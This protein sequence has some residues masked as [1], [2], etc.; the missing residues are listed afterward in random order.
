MNGINDW[1]LGSVTAVLS[2]VGLFVASR[3][4]EEVAY[5]GGLVFFAF[6]VG[7]ILFQVKRAWDRREQ[8]R[9]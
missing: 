3:A 8:G 7:L 5:Y 9:H 2:L 1:I 6:A 4:E